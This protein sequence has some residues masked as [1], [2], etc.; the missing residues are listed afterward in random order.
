MEPRLLTHVKPSEGSFKAWHNGNP[1]RAN[2]WHYHPEFEIT[3][4]ES[5][6]GTFFVGDH[7]EHYDNNDLV[8]LGGNLPHEWRISLERDDYINT[9]SSIAIH[10][11]PDFVGDHFLSLPET[12]KFKN[13]L[14]R[15]R[16]GLKFTNKETI[17]EVQHLIRQML[18]LQ[19][20]KKMVNFLNVIECLASDSTSKQLCSPGFTQTFQ[21]MET[22]KISVVFQYL[23][24]NFKHDISLEEVS[25]KT[26]MTP[27][28]FCRWFK[29]SSGKTFI[30]YLNEVRTGYSKKLL[31][32]DNLSISQI[33]FEAGFRNISN[34]NKRFKNIHGLTPSE[35]RSL[36]NKTR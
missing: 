3:L 20:L 14:E 19:G 4:I 5:G 34:F 28:A 36:L 32:G 11:L 10:F 8:L 15:A 13:L 29:K 9:E 24:K 1:Y 21:N 6:A 35:Y 33:A 22:E 23:M 16:F 18:S 17:A 25:D 7:I 2:P 30:E 27:N 31:Q 26:C 12:L